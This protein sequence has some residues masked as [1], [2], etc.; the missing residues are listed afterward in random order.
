MV[1]VAVLLVL[2]VLH[3]INQILRMNDD[4]VSGHTRR[5]SSEQGRLS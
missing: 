5:C 3:E 1:S 2:T 4:A